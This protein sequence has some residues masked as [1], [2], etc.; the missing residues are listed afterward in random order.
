MTDIHVHLAA[1]PTAGNGCVLSRRMRGSLLLSWVARW[2]GLSL[3]DPAAT[4]RRYVELLTEE[5]SR[6]THVKQ[7]VLLAMDGVYDS[8]GELDEG[9]TDFLISNDYLF[10][11][12]AA[13]QRF[14]P[15]ASI[16]PARKDSLDELDRCSEKGAVLV[17]VLPNAQGFDPAERRFGAFYRRLAALRM[18]LLS[19]TGYEFSLFAQD[20][21]LGDP[22]RLVPVLEEGVTVIAAHG[23]G[24]GL[25]VAGRYFDTML[26]LMRRY[27]N[28][29]VDSSA[30]T[31]PVR[32]GTLFKMKRYPEIHERLL[33]GTDYP[34]PCLSYPCLGAFAFDKFIESR[35]ATNRFDRQVHVLNALGISAA[36]DATRLLRRTE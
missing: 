4:N 9:R 32:V 15:G 25:F 14:L 5:L 18:P 3:S 29:Y 19:H 17:K 6:S 35:R 8:T 2:Q 12:A 13:H 36:A 1:L 10:E 34:L 21:R 28:F 20:Q 16:N 22:A 23:C 7:A 24:S 26:R 33:F 31:L 11:V 30:L 27:P